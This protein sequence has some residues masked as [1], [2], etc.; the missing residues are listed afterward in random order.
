MGDL[1]DIAE[2]GSDIERAKLVGKCAQLLLTMS[3]LEFSKAVDCMLGVTITV[4]SASACRSTRL[5]A[6]SLAGAVAR[7]ELTPGGLRELERVF[8]ILRDL[9]PTTPLDSLPRALMGLTYAV[10]LLPESPC[11]AKWMAQSSATLE[12]MRSREPVD[13]WSLLGMSAEHLLSILEQELWHELQTKKGAHSW[14]TPS[15]TA[16]GHTS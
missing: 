6:L 13:A 16:S 4:D 12:M 14:A 15:T 11:L 7:L 3:P 1:V 5:A 2:R 9:S 10:A 8:F